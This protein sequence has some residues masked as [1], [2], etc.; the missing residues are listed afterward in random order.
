MCFSIDN[1]VKNFVILILLCV[2]SSC[3]SQDISLVYPKNN[4]VTNKVHFFKWNKISNVN[5]YTIQ[6]SQD[7]ELTNSFSHNVDTHFFSVNNELS[8]GV[9]YWRV[10]AIDSNGNN[11]QSSIN[12][13]TLFSPTQLSSLSLW[14]NADSLINVNANNEI[15]SWG[16]LS[17]N[18]FQAIQNNASNKPLL[19]SNDPLMNSLTT[20]SFDGTQDF[21]SLGDVLDLSMNDRTTFTLFN[22][23][24]VVYAKFGSTV[25]PFNLYSLENAGILIHELAGQNYNSVTINNAYSGINLVSTRLNRQ[26]GLVNLKRNNSESVSELI[27]GL[28]SNYNFN[29]SNPLLIGAYTSTPTYNFN[30]SIAEIIFCDEYL[31]QEEYALVNNYLMDRVCPPVDLGYDT[32]IHYGFCDIQLTANEYY[33]T[34]LWSTGETTNYC[35]VNE[36]GLYWVEVIDVFGRT[37]R[38]SITV[39]R[40]PVDSTSLGPFYL[41]PNSTL[42][43][44]AYLPSNTT[45]LN[46]NNGETN[47]TI[48]LNEES[49]VYY[50]LQDT[51]G[52]LH[53]SDNIEIILDSSI[54]NFTL[55]PDTTLCE[56]NFLSINDTNN[57]IIS[58]LWS[59]SSE[60][61]EL[62]VYE[63]GVYSVYFTNLNNCQNADTIS[64][65]ISGIAP[66][67]NYSIEEV[68]CLQ[69][70][71]LFSDSSYVTS[72]DTISSVIWSF[73]DFNSSTM[74]SGS[75]VY[76]NPGIYN[77]SIEVVTS[78]DCS[79]KEFFEVVVNPKPLMF[80][81]TQNVCPYDEIQFTPTNESGVQIIE[82]HWDF[83]H[84]NETSNLED[85]TY[86][87]GESNIYNVEVM[88]EDVN[89]CR[90]T[91]VQEVYIQ[92]APVANIEFD[93]I[94]ELSELTFINNSS[95]SDS[96]TIETYEWDYGDGT[97]Y[98]NPTI[99]KVYQGYGNYDLEIILSANN[100][101]QDTL[102]QEI[103]VHPQPMLNW[104]IG[105][106]CKN[107][108][109]TFENQSSIS[110]GSIE[111]TNWLVNLQYTLNGASSGYE[112]VTTGIQYLNLTSTSNEGCQKDTLI[113]IDVQP[114]LNSTYNINPPNAIAGTPIVFTPNE[115]SAV[116]YEWNFGNGESTITSSSESVENVYWDDDIGS[117]METFLI[118][119]N[120]IGCMDTSFNYL[121]INETRVD[122]SI[123]N[124]F[125]QD[126]NGYF[127]IGVEL[128]NDGL[129]D[130]SKIDLILNI[131]NGVPILESDNSGLLA[132]ESKIYIFSAS[133]SSTISI[134]DDNQAFICVDANSYNDY[135]LQ[136]N[137]LTNNKICKNIESENLV[138]LP[139]NPNPLNEQLN[140]SIL[141]SNNSEITIQ[142]YDINSK[143]LSE[144]NIEMEIGLNEFNLSVIELSK[145]TYYLRI[146]DGSKEIIK[147]LIKI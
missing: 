41:C 1:I 15:N 25:A 13:L 121:T 2:F 29:S 36:S 19:N 93:L 68:L 105:P 88:V 123:E 112:F 26:Q 83:D 78:G 140:I 147:K 52:C 44:S 48:Q 129:I 119:E 55:G 146:L 87:Y 139:I 75:H 89:G 34:Y 65:L 54:Y 5:Y 128:K 133:P 86:T 125:V 46:W 35:S 98:V 40:P 53:Q 63:S 37:S 143:L 97:T 32:T 77:A 118:V 72:T 131:L 27:S 45:F 82:Y 43:I 31:N 71:F 8:L 69:D 24:G 23:S 120:E 3:F 138:L 58:Y 99:P 21:F 16:D 81:T 101:C 73:G 50:S 142:L 57:F 107:S 74:S 59:D 85:P 111:Q 33:T 141:M 144:K 79:S 104:Q 117:V 100:G 18:S 28:P 106:A 134:Q 130:I 42:E 17:L 22:G 114:E 108:W 38:D 135:N 116:S 90:D 110:F 94:C 7:A 20:I 51:L 6:F 103:T 67:L 96:F 113:L 132:G 39:Y 30:G 109:T 64:I 14:L 145:G 60:L 4:F 95:I 47:T 115:Q 137:D 62:Q 127:S 66:Q 70:A 102:F 76:Y 61:N 124:M 84:N 49:I 56:G 136:E 91:T 9:W 12:K 10:T 122:L 92:P 126:V 11:H 80:F